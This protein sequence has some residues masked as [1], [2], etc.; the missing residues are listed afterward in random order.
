MNGREGG[1]VCVRGKEGKKEGRKDEGMLV[2]ALECKQSVY[3]II[4]QYL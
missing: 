4:R 1:I 3:Y 2:N